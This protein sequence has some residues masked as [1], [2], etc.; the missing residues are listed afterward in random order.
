MSTRFLQDTR[1]RVAAAD[2]TTRQTAEFE[3][4][5]SV[6][7]QE[8]LQQNGHVRELVGLIRHAMEEGKGAEVSVS[9]AIAP[10]PENPVDARE[11]KSEHSGK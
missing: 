5:I 9:A 7:F 4:A 8:Y 1:A 3:R 6:K 10:Q 11:E 2:L